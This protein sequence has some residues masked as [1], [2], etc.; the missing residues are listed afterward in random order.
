MAGALA[1]AFSLVAKHRRK[2]ERQER[3]VAMALRI[4]MNVDKDNL[5]TNAALAIV[6]LLLLW[7]CV[8]S[9]GS[10]ASGA[11]APPPADSCANEASAPP[12]ALPATGR[13]ASAAWGAR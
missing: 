7:I 2:P 8:R 4:E 9:I 5:I 6:A 10:G 1:M 11:A 12:V 13:D 3:G